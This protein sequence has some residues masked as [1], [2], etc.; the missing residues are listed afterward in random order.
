MRRPWRTTQ[1]PL[2]HEAAASAGRNLNNTDVSGRT[3]RINLA[4]SD[5]FLESKAKARREL[6]D[7]GFPGPS[8]A[9]PRPQQ[10]PRGGRAPKTKSLL[11]NLPLS[12]QAPRGSSV[13]DG[14]LEL[15]VGMAPQSAH[16][17][18]SSDE[19]TSTRPGISEIQPE[20]VRHFFFF[21]FCFAFFLLVLL[22]RHRSF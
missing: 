2:D 21:I 13:L 16:G 3:L 20:H 6:L 10:H 5:P 7:G 14:I 8:L 22:L 17:S 15:L 18:V 11:A 19:G 12:I 1:L 9:E 4:D